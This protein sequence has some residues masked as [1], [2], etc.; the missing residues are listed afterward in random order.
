MKHFWFL[1][2]KLRV[3]RLYTKLRK[4]EFYTEK[5]NLLGFKII[6]YYVHMEK[7]GVDTINN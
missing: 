7:L 1:I 3:A 2:E 5:V 6:P 4:C